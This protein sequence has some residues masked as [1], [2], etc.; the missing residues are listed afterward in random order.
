VAFHNYSAQLAAG[1]TGLSAVEGF[2]IT[3]L[4]LETPQLNHNRGYYSASIQTSFS[5]HA[6]SESKVN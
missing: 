4:K 1:G 3:T 2:I 5:D 6:A